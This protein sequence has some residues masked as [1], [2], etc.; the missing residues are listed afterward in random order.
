MIMKFDYNIFRFWREH[1]KLTLEEV[2]KKVGVSKANVQKW[3]AGKVIPRR[4]KIYAISKLFNI[5][6]YDISDI[7]PEPEISSKTEKLTEA[8]QDPMFEIVLNSWDKLSGSDK[9]TLI[10]T[11][12]NILKQKSLDK[13]SI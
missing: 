11:I 12:Q 9:G 4:S 7:P 10:E 5:D 1:Y 6:P 2:G 13:E 8:L 3:E